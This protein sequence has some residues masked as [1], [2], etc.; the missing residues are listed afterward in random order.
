MFWCVVG[1]LVGVVFLLFWW[2]VCFGWELFFVTVWW[3]V[4]LRAMVVWVFGFWY[5]VKLFVI[6]DW[7]WILGY[8]LMIGL[9]CDLDCFVICFVAY[10]VSFNSVASLLIW[11]RVVFLFKCL[12][13][14]WLFVYLIVVYCIVCVVYCL[15]A[16]WFVNCSFVWLLCYVYDWFAHLRLS[17]GYLLLFTWLLCSLIGFVI[18]G[19]YFVSWFTDLVVC[20]A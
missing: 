4:E 15:F 9:F 14:A 19:G 2:C 20:F 5:F 10:F 16:V 6:C 17:L 3:L 7:L 13:T 18:C 1:D 8:L 12:L 11:I